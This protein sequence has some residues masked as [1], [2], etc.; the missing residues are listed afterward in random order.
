MI[1]DLILEKVREAAGLLGLPGERV[2]TKSTKDNLTLPRPRIE[3]DFLPETYESSGRLLGPPA[4]AENIGRYKRELYLV[5]LP[6]AAQI[7]ASD[8]I[9]LKEFSHRLVAA[10]PRGFNDS[11]GNYV[12]LRASEG[13]WEGY[14]ARRVGDQ[15]IDPI[16]RR[17]YLL[18]L[19]AAWRVTREELVNYIRSVN[20]NHHIIVG[21]TQ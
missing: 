6:I 5:S 4:A 17:G 8:P 16:V 7:L 3:L 19:G 20:L 9:W 14:S 11:A 15:V 13:E 2:M 21:G 1:R 18:H 12:K 10:L